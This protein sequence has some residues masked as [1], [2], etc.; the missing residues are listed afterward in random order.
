[1]Q[2][3]EVIG[4]LSSLSI[5]GQRW[6]RGFLTLTPQQAQALGVFK[7]G[8]F[9]QGISV[10]G[11]TLLGLNEGTEYRMR[12]VI[13]DHP[14]YGRSLDV[15]AATIELECNPDALA[16][17]L[18]LNIR[19]VGEVS[20]K[21]IVKHYAQ[22]DSLDE[23][24]DILLNNP[25]ALDIGAALNQKKPK[26][27][28]LKN[29]ADQT[30]EVF[31][32]RDLAVRLGGNGV[33]DSTLRKIGVWLAARIDQPESADAVTRAWA[34]FQSDPYRPMLDVSGY[35]FAQADLIGGRFGID[36]HAPGRIAAL[37]MSAINQGC[38]MYGHVFLNWGEFVDMIGKVDPAVDPDA[39]INAAITRG[40][41][42]LVESDT[43]RV[44]TSKLHGAQNRLAGLL[45]KMLGRSIMPLYEKED[46]GAAIRA[47]ERKMPT[48]N[49]V[50][51]RLDDSQRAALSGILTSRKQVHTLTAGPGC[52]KTALME[53][54]VE[55][56]GR[57]RV[58]LFCAPTGKAAKVLSGRISKFNLRAQTIHT[59]LGVTE[60]GFNHKEDNPVF[61]DFVVVDESSMND[62]DLTGSLLAAI[63]PKCH[64]VFLGDTNQLPSVGPGQVLA[65]LLKLPC[66]HHHLTSTHRNDG[67]ILATVN[68]AARGVMSLMDYED[69]KFSRGLPEASADAIAPIL[70]EYERAVARHGINAVALLC[71]RRKGNVEQP[72]WNTTYLNKVLRE[73]MNP[74][75]QPIKGTS[76]FT[77][78]RVVVRKNMRLVQEEDKDGAPPVIEAVVNGD[79]G[80]VQEAHYGEKG[81][82]PEYIT[83]KFDD[84]RKVKFESAA[85][86]VLGL[87]Y[88]V[89]VHTSQGSEYAEVLFICTNGM[90]SFMHRGIVFTA[91]SR[92]KKMLRIYGENGAIHSVV[93]RPIPQRNSAL[94]EMIN[95]VQEKDVAQ[96][97]GEDLVEPA[98]QLDW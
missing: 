84:G 15:E 1:M 75:G 55:I 6:G 71:A 39:A 30:V 90:P 14:T 33:M 4:T 29:S 13:K 36:R 79:T 48:P 66:D 54:L 93:K 77:G 65:D 2:K 83:I 61:A 59:M 64:V 60:D 82:E 95:G 25:H 17:Y 35:G 44:Y 12:G 50:F 3:A 87:A 70:L 9:F 47:A 89:T 67:G 81:H 5:Y 74:L 46:V 11:A 49:G 16:K 26:M 62:V 68:E 42:V 78:D 38:E 96:D 52:G 86:G 10:T 34:L 32:H 63:P 31:I 57:S 51:F 69:V 72:G 80:T 43:R 91:L 41:P 73:R 53:L 85:I 76:L 28:A 92:A 21:K 40:W 20:A 56:L 98:I 8:M 24:R 27:A 22:R 18:R 37:A 23:L 88:A 7:D 58:G 94:V 97:Q 45:K 19:G